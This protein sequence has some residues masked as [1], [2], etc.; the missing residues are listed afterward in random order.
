[1]NSNSA[2]DEQ[3]SLERKVK[4]NKLK[5]QIQNEQEDF[6]RASMAF[7]TNAFSEQRVRFNTVKERRS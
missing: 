7:F 6:H 1:M 2:R 3:E 5:N 4:I